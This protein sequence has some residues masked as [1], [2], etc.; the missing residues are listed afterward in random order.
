ML[1]D[2]FRYEKS[3]KDFYSLMSGVFQEFHI[4][5]ILNNPLIN[6]LKL[7]NVSYFY[8]KNDFWEFGGWQESLDKHKDSFS[9]YDFFI[10]ANDT[11]GTSHQISLAQKIQILKFIHFSDRNKPSVSGNYSQL[12]K[13]FKPGKIFSS[14]WIQSYFFIIN[15]L[16]MKQINYN[17]IPP[18]EKLDSI[19]SDT[20][21]F[22]SE[23]CPSEVK[24]YLNDWL[25]SQEKGSWKDSQILDEKN[26]EFFKLKAKMILTEKLLNSEFKKNQFI[27]QKIFRLRNIPILRRFSYE[28]K[29][30]F[31]NS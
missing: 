18:S 2:E 11:Y 22:Y 5:V 24:R 3:L 29:E 4:V 19:I 6:P 15:G 10:F 8:G 28:S 14:T 23:S 1:Y 7:D 25:F 13:K 31:D 30:R 20:S 26:I 17:L 9:E 21:S 27:I 12:K 16:G